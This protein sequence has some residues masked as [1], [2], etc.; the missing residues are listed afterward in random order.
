MNKLSGA[1][2]HHLEAAQ[3]WLERS[4]YARCFDELERIDH[5][6]RGDARVYTVRWSLYN[7]SGQHI[8]AANLARG[9]QGRFP[10]EIA[11]YIWR[12]VSLNKSGCTQEA[13]DELAAVAQKFDGAGAVP[14]VLSI[15]ATDLK[16]YESART[17]LM[18]AFA[19]EDGQELKLRALEEKSLDS[20]WRKIGEL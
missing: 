3:G 9:V 20:F 16:Q 4:D 6:N 19:T 18:K 15:L 17:W 5:N 1:D 8:A 12:A 11:G 10:H 13:Y 2:I 7:R 14:Y